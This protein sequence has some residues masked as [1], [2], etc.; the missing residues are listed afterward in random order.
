MFVNKLTGE[1]RLSLPKAGTALSAVHFLPL[2]K[3]P[4]M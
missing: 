4:E 1:M 3:S 2:A